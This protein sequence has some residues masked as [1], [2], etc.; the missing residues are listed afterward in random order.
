MSRRTKRKKNKR[1][2]KVI[3][4][5]LIIACLYFGLKKFGFS[6]DNLIFDSKK[7]NII[8]EKSNSRNI[9]I[10]INNHN[11]ARPYH[12]GLDD[13]YIIYEMIAEGGLTRYMAIFKDKDTQTIG[14]IRSSRHYFLDYVLENDAIYVHFG[15]S[16]Q[17]QEDI[18]NLKI[19]NIN[20]L[21]YDNKYFYRDTSL[22]VATE[23]T[24]YTSMEKINK[25][26][27][28]L[29]YKNTTEES[30]LL[31][32]SIDSL[33]LAS[34]ENSQEVNELT[35]EYSKYVI[36]TYKYDSENKVYKRYVN[37]EEHKDYITKNQYTFK[38]IIVYQVAN[39]SI[40][41]YGRQELDNIGSGKGYYISE[42]YAIPINWEKIS[43]SSKTKYTLENGEELKVNDGN[44]FIQIQPKNKSLVLN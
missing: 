35:I 36:D 23:H 19:D 17:A 44:T 18:K 29:K 14:S 32:Y 12:S 20:G 10:M 26:I 16:P 27:Q 22:P 39:K 25:A 5:L 4:L 21:Y 1:F 11:K 30:P 2:F 8:D 6:L 7:L 42:G 38:N 28:D 13:A 37:N 40:D 3:I 15:W 41:S 34:K 33:D 9:A 43:R 31:K 24:A